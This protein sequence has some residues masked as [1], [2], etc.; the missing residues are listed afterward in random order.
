MRPLHE[1][2]VMLE[3]LQHLLAHLEDPRPK[4]QFSQ[5]RDPKTGTFKAGTKITPQAVRKAAGSFGIRPPVRPTSAAILKLRN[6][7]RAQFRKELLAALRRPAPK[8]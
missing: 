3:R 4:R 5:A 6:A 2:R 8:S 7:D 1:T